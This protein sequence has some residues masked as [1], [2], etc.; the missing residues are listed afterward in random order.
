MLSS[1]SSSVKPR[2]L[3]TVLAGAELRVDGVVQT[4]ADGAR[5][6]LGGLRRVV[7]D[8][9]GVGLLDAREVLVALHL[10][11]LALA[12][13]LDDA[14]V[15]LLA[16]AEKDLEEVEDVGEVTERDHVVELEAREAQQVAVELGAGVLHGDRQLVDGGE[17]VAHPA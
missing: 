14:V 10:G 6:L 13:E 17:Q 2:I 3:A 4:P 12:S 1:P 16:R 11:D 5:R 7:A 15:E 8:H 9:E